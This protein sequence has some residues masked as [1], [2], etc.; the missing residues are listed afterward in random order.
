MNQYP[1]QNYIG[2]T[3]GPAGFSPNAQWLPSSS[4]GE[5]SIDSILRIARRYFWLVGICILLGIAYASYKNARSVPIYQATASVQLTQD[6]ANQFRLD[7]G[8]MS[9]EIDSIRLDTEIS[10]LR[11]QSLALETIQSLKLDKNDEFVPHPP[12][13]AWDLSN[14]RDRHALTSVFIGSL[15]AVRAGH[16]NILYI[17]YSSP[18]PTL[19]AQICNKHIENYVEHNFKDNYTTTEQV[20]KWLQAQLGEL[21]RRL[22]SS[23]E[24]MLVLQNQIGIVGIDQTQSIALTRLEGLNTDL[25]KVESERMTQE[26]RLIAM[27]S[28]S[29]E[30]LAT[31]SN[32][33]VIVQLRTKRAALNDE[34]VTMMS[35]YGG[36]NPRVVNLRAE[37][38]GLDE[39]I[40]VEEM[41]VIRRAEKEVESSYQQ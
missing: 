41:T 22:E 35:K 18:N 39:A 20:S 32:D 37:I 27:K 34:Y 10:I 12:G 5:T 38:T 31:L 25:T 1:E 28:S 33:P 21:R 26:A 9:G 17:S 14:S 6:S 29:P 7:G 24:R 3:E 30:V 13:R 8:A 16:T 40:R 4:E 15:G 19:A 11:S 36:A 23:Q 2:E